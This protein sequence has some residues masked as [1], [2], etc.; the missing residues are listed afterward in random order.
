MDDTVLKELSLHSRIGVIEFVVI[1]SSNAFRFCTE[2][3]VPALFL[4]AR[5]AVLH[6]SRTF[7]ATDVTDCK[8]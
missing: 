5:C 7:V 2:R 1:L 4:V 3:L 6:T 8:E